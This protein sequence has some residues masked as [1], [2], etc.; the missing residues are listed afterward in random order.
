MNEVAFLEHLRHKGGEE[1]AEAGRSIIAAMRGARG[2]ALSW[3][4][5]PRGRCRVSVD[6]A[7]DLTLFWL[8][9]DGG[10][11]W[12]FE[13]L[14]RSTPLQEP[15]TFGVLRARLGQLPGAGYTDAD[16]EKSANLYRMKHLDDD[17][18]VVK[19]RELVEWVAATVSG[20]GGR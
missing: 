15:N 8:D 5:G 7:R 3:G 14:R 19:F 1:L 17:P 11:R 13:E 16:L 12:S 6:D 20:A 4:E 18:A 9:I 2:V 10:I